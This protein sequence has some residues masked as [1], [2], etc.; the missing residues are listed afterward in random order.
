MIRSSDSIRLWSAD[1]STD[2]EGDVI[3]VAAN[4]CTSSRDG[5]CN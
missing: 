4:C 2:A 3:G 1:G 5:A